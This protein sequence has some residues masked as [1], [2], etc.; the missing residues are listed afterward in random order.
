M[1]TYIDYPSQGGRADNACGKFSKGDTAMELVPPK[2][3][4]SIVHHD[5]IHLEYY[6]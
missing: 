4:G 6:S 3:L 1:T 5:I 2:D